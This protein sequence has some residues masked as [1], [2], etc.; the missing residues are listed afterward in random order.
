M[1]YTAGILM[2]VTGFAIMAFGLFLFYAWLPLLYGLIGL[3]IGLLVG[4]SLTGTVGI[5]AIILGI[6]GAI[7]FGAASYFLE[8]YRR[9]LLGVSG[10]ILVGLSL[11]VLLALDRLFGGVF[12]T[13]LALVCGLI[14]G[15]VLPRY[16]DALV[17]AASAFGGAVMVMT[18]ANLILPDIGLFDRDAG[19][20][21]PILLTLILAAIGLGWQFSNIEKWVH[22]AANSDR[23]TSH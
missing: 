14:G 15:F 18:G 7:L 1:P 19:G 22:H 3:E 11:A 13:I 4:K 5:V 6:A 17:I 21:L 10:G 2:I 8:P 23:A 9:I 16:F 12:A 20:L